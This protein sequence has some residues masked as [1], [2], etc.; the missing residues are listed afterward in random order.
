MRFEPRNCEHR[1]DVE[2]V[3]LFISPSERSVNELTVAPKK[4][5][6]PRIFICTGICYWEPSLQ[7]CVG[8]NDSEDGKEWAKFQVA[9]AIC[10]ANSERDGTGCKGAFRN[11]FTNTEFSS[12]VHMFAVRLSLSMTDEYILQLPCGTR[13]AV[14]RNTLECAMQC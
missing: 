3:K 5:S 12:A 10:I 13:S 4:S 8:T 9:S 2:A 11:S 7:F 14:V 6:A 1:S